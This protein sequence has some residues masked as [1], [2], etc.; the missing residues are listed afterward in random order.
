MCCGWESKVD[1]QPKLVERI[2]AV[3]DETA[4]VEAW[5]PSAH[6]LVIVMVNTVV[7]IARG[8]RGCTVTVAPVGD[9]DMRLGQEKLN[10]S[11]TVAMVTHGPVRP[12]PR[13]ITEAV[14][15]ALGV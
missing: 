5:T 9:V 11:L 8:E 7:R 14:D 3:G 10:G 13:D 4:V 15:A 12:T 6:P 1:E 2:V